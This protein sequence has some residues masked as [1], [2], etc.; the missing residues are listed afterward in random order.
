VTGI[1][2]AGA[3]KSVP[4]IPVGRYSICSD[5]PRCNMF[6]FLLKLFIVVDA[7][8]RFTEFS[9]DR[10]DREIRYHQLS[11]KDFVDRCFYNVLST[12]FHNQSVKSGQNPDR[13]S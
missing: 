1:Q 12:L 10:K 6:S 8:E 11:L 5:Q 13:L 9:S 4:S 2:H 3:R 7:R